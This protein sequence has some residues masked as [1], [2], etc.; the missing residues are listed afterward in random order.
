MRDS[1]SG[2]SSHARWTR[3]AAR[4]DG[5]CRV[6]CTVLL[7]ALGIASSIGARDARG[8][9]W[10]M[11]NHDARGTRASSRERILDRHSVK[12]LHVKWSFPTIGVVNGTPVVQGD[13]VYAG[14]GTGMVYALDRRGRLRW[15]TQLPGVITASALI[16]RDV[17]VIGDLLGNLYGLA[18]RDGRVRWAMRPD[19]HPVASLYGSGTDVD[20]D[21]VIGVSSN[22]ET[23]AADPLYPC[24]ST[25]GSVL[26]I[27]PEN[28]RIKWQTFMVSDAERAAGASGASVWSTPAFDD[29][30]GTIYVTTGNNFSEPSTTTSDAVIALDART[31]AFRWVN[32]RYPD[33]TWTMRFPA[34]PPHPDYDFGDS[35]QLYQL[36]DGRQVVGAGQKSGFYHV[37]DAATGQAVQQIQ[38]EPGGPL[39]GLFADT[40]VAGGVVYANGINWPGGFGTPPVAGDLVAIAGDG[41]RE[42]WRFTTPQAP[43]LSGVA[44]AAGVVYFQSDFAKALFALDAG[45]GALLAQVV[46]GG[47]VSGPS[48]ADGQIYIGIGDTFTVG[49]TG[50]GAI[51]ALGL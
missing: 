31:G 23:V 27:D 51:T 29:T 10:P 22:E 18:Q 36:P 25:R 46:I 30:S 33:D 20:G 4:I 45:T 12:G 48:I 28:G 14:D 41:S 50:P 32:Q 13:R 17:V 6:S 40:A 37:L 39:G 34:T 9:G 1:E 26:R 5:R 24:C 11:Y 35:P 44:T 7:V 8:D 21:V 47:S 19:P 3:S 49:P 2:G 15:Q 16:I 42:L 38:V 43:D